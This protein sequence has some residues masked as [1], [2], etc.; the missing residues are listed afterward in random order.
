MTGLITERPIPCVNYNTIGQRRN[1]GSKITRSQISFAELAGAAASF[2]SS[3]KQSAKG[4]AAA[5]GG[6]TQSHAQR[7]AA[8]AQAGTQRSWQ[9][10]LKNKMGTSRASVGNSG[11]VSNP[12]KITE[13]GFHNDLVN[14][15]SQGF[16]AGSEDAGKSQGFSAGSEDAG[17]RF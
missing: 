2:R 11:P 1:S 17:K 8:A 15:V 5:G 13:H 7:H 6:G 9:S 10:L 14:V 16:S 12:E 4:G 3:Q